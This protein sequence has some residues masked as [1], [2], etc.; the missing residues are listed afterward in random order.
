MVHIEELKFD[1]ITSGAANDIERCSQLARSMVTQLGM[2]NLG[3]MAYGKKDEMVFLGREIS[4]QRNY[5]ESVA[6]NI[7]EEVKRLVQEAYEKAKEILREYDDKLVLVA[8]KLLEVETL[9]QAE[10]EELFPPPN[11][12]SSSTPQPL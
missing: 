6:E 9:S 1:D 7:D 5:S 10:F 2:S 11:G 4:E 12:K 3:P 8:E